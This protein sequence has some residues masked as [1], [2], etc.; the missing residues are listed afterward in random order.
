MQ[1]IISFRLWG[2]SLLRRIFSF[3]TQESCHYINGPE[4]LPPPLTKEEEA[5]VIEISAGG[6]PTPGNPLSPTISDWWCTSPKNLKAPA[7]A[8]RI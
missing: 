4:T 8:W 6:R 1:K 2:H 7:P 5:Q 3:W